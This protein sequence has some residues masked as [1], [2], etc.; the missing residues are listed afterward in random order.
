MA[1]G[2]QVSFI[3][4]R[5]IKLLVVIEGP[6]A[7]GKTALS[8]EVAKHFYTVI[9]SA[10]SRQFY[11]EMSIGTAKPTISEMNGI[12]HYFINSHSV[13][14]ELTA[15]TFASAAKQILDKE[16]VSH[17]L[18]IL[19]GGSGMYVDALCKGLDDVPVSP[20]H[21][22]QLNYEYSAR[23]LKTLLAELEAADPIHFSKIDKSNHARVI[24]ALEVIRSTGKPYSNFLRKR[25]NDNDFEVIRFRIEHS[26]DQL[27]E[28]INNRVDQ[29]MDAGLLDEV[30]SLL[31]LRDLTPLQ[32]VGYKE[33]FDFIDGKTDLESAVNLIKQHTRNYAKRQ[34]TWLRKNQDALPIEFGSVEDMT[35]MIVLQLFQK[36]N[37]AI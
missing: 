26:R 28:R 5:K 7:S 18:I 24:R 36:Y 35:K 8:V 2:L 20:A 10:D 13:K 3:F 15:A 1:F 29:M 32:T 25:R 12:K 27:Y 14:E 22:S 30:R 16:F 19:T 31:H 4:E 21:R 6:T 33:L 11:Q 17:P 9:L 23:G 34:L 37:L